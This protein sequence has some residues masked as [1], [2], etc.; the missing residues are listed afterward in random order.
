MKKTPRP[1]VDR[2]MMQMLRLRRQKTGN[3]AWSSQMLGLVPSPKQLLGNGWVKE[4]WTAH[5]HQEPLGSWLQGAPHL[6]W[7]FELTGEFVQ[8]VDRDEASARAEPRPLCTVQLQQSMV[9][10]THS[11]GLPISLQEALTPADHWARNEHSQPLQ[12]T[13]AHVF[14]RS[15]CPPAPPRAPTWPPCKI[16]CTIQPPLPNLGALLYLI[17][18]SVTQ[19]SLKRNSSRELLKKQ[20]FISKRE[21]KSFSDKQMLREFISTRQALQKVLKGVLNMEWKEHLLPQKHT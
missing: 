9:I 18:Y 1:R 8:R 20:S 19:S 3:P 13:G 16:M 11:P 17:V 2:D 5:P 21:I 12:W 4:L 15:S 10:G 14:C 7:M 6:P